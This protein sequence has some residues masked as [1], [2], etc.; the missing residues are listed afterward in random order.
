VDDK[1][2][3]C[4]TNLEAIISFKDELDSKEQAKK[5]QIIEIMARS[6]LTISPEN[7]TGLLLNET[8]F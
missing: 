2:E 6:T 3:K 4:I 5:K 1:I 8:G 7:Q